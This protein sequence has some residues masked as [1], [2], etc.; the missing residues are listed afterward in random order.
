MRCNVPYDLELNRVVRIVRSKKA[1][2]VLIQLPN[3]LKQYWNIIVNELTSKTPH[4]K[5]LVSTSS[6]YGGC[7]VAENEARILNADLIIHYGHT[8]YYREKFPT[9]YVKA[10]SK[11]NI[12]NETYYKLIQSLKQLKI[13]N[14]GLSA[15]IQHVHLLHRV[16]KVLEEYGFK[17]YIGVS[18]SKL[19]VSYSGQVIGCNYTTALAVNKLVD[20]HLIVSG[21]Y[22]HAIGLGISTGKPVI[23]VD[24]YTNT[25]E[26]VSDK[27]KKVLNIRY[28]KIMQALDGRL[29]AI[30]VGSKP[31][32]YRPSLIRSLMKEMKRKSLNYRVMVAGELNDKVLDNIDNDAIDVYVVT[33]CP[34]LAIDDLAHYRKPVLTPGETYMI[35]RGNLERYVFP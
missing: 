23:K 6:C 25:V 26:D 8:R 20:L 14:I 12:K 17:A 29:Y 22:F 33:S 34:R 27:V 3:G 24:P 16:K 21:G 11:L 15:T 32:Q 35:L 28:G 1:R 19:Q 4:V 9:I 7:D 13:K 31:G 10:K 30:I 18:K 2:K 5:Y